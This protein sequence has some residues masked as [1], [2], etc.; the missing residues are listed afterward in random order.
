[1]KNYS[2]INRNELLTDTTTGMEFKGMILNKK[3]PVSKHS[4]FY[5]PSCNDQT[6]EMEKRLVVAS[7][8]EMG[9]SVNIK[10]YHDGGVYPSLYMG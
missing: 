9:E 4:T 3:R 1:M 5:K 8:L 2:V 10:G 7:K 6:I